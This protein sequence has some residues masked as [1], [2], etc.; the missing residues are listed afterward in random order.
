M[1]ILKAAGLALTAMVL[2]LFLRQYLPAYAML[3]LAGAVLLLC[4]QFA[5]AAKP[6]LVWLE[7]V[8]GLAGR[9]EFAC[10]LKAAGIALIAQNTQELCKD[11]G[12][13]ALGYGVEL[14]GR[15]LI[16]AAA[17]PLLRQVLDRLMLM[18]Q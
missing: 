5:A 8:S 4:V 11:A 13:G 9:E 10:L 17:L 18:M 1:E 6:V 16:L 15:C 3:G 2:V 14:A 12:L 7:E